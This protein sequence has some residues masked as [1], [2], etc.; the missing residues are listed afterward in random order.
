MSHGIIVVNEINNE[1]EFFN[2]QLKI[3]F[4]KG[5]RDPKDFN[6]FKY[7][8]KDPFKNEFEIQTLFILI[9]KNKFD[10]THLVGPTVP[11][12]RPGPSKSQTRK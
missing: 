7:R 5:S 3:R 11:G 4:N 1:V 6:F 12:A 8:Y 10:I 2:N 9:V